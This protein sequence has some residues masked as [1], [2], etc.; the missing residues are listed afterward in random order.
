MNEEQAKS[1]ARW[2][3]ATFGPFLMAHGYTQSTMEMWAG[4][5][6]SAAPLIW[7]MFVHT[8]SNAVK[9]VDKLA[10]ESS[11]PVLAVVVA[12]NQ[13]GKD[14]ANAMPGNTT[15]VAGTQQAQAAV[16]V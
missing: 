10:K 15:V 4:V 13:A 7:S 6:V 12:S 3:V 5:F 16:K 14:L 11:S 9:V 1:F 2:I 8:E